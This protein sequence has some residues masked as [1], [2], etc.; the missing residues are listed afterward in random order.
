[1]LVDYTT[2]STIDNDRR[3]T[4][5]YKIA[6]LTSHNIIKTK[7]SSIDIVPLYYSHPYYNE[8]RDGVWQQTLMTNNYYMSVWVAIFRWR[9]EYRRDS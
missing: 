6:Y 9:L 1:M 8:F 5:G 7:H 2:N 3:P 4:T